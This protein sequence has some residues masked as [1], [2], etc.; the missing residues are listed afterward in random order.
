MTSKSVESRREVNNEITT[1]NEF[2]YIYIYLIYEENIKY[3]VWIQLCLEVGNYVF[4]R[5]NISVVRP[6]SLIKICGKSVK[7]VYEL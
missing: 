3:Q 2:T 6:N 1:R 7:M 4:S 5:K